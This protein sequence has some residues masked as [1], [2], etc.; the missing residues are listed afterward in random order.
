MFAFGNLKEATL[1]RT[2][3]NKIINE[4]TKQQTLC[5]LC[6]IKHLIQVQSKNIKQ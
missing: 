4:H 3:I 1:R 5:T 6:D 2:S